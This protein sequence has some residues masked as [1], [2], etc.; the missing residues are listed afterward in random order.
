MKILTRRI[1]LDNIPASGR[2]GALV[3]FSSLPIILAGAIEAR[4]Y[5]PNSAEYGIGIFTGILFLLAS[6]FTYRLPR[7]AGI[8]SFIASYLTIRNVFTWN[9][10]LYGAMYAEEN[11]FLCGVLF[12]FLAFTVT[13]VKKY[14][15]KSILKKSGLRRAE[16]N[17]K[18]A[19]V[20]LMPISFI[21]ILGSMTQPEISPGIRFGYLYLLCVICAT[22]AYKIILSNTRKKGILFG[23]GTLFG[24][25]VTLYF[26]TDPLFCLMG[27]GLVIPI[28]LLLAPRR[29]PAGRNVWID[30]MLQQ[31]AR[32]LIVTFFALCTTGTLLLSIPLAT[33]GPHS[34]LDSLF[35]AVSASCV[36]GLS[37][38]DT[39]KDFTLLGQIIILALIQLGGLGIISITTVT[40]QVLGKRLSLQQECILTNITDTDHSDLL[41]SI[42][43]I[44]KVTFL[45]EAV[46]AVLLFFAFMRHGDTWIQAIWR[47]IFTSISAFCNAG[48]SLQS[49]SLM[50][51]QKDPFL[52]TVVSILIIIGGFAPTTTVLI[53]RWIKGRAIANTVRLPL[54]TTIWLLIFGTVGILIFEFN[55]TLEPLNLLDKIANAWFQ[56]VTL[57]TA[58]FNSIDISAVSQ[59]TFMLMV[60]LMLIGGSPGGTAGGVKT[61]TIGL[62]AVTFWS[63]VTNKNEVILRNRLIHHTT[64]YRAI[65]I[66]FAGMMIWLMVLLMLQVTH[67]L[68]GRDLLFEA[69]SAIATVGLTTGATSALN[70][71]GKI[72][73]VVTMFL[74]RIGPVSLFMLLSLDGTDS[75][76]ERA[77]R[78]KISLT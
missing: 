67:D 27:C 49:A 26:S 14:Q 76:A 32:V 17:A 4:S 61:S 39:E 75:H 41:K 2:Q 71:F 53:P 66:L 65:T 20:L 33:K 22:F 29:Q 57:R 25:I 52:L 28:I 59:P 21:A 62:L 63:N 69:S 68:P 58:G 13:N 6:A 8:I 50:P 77:P 38:L 72:I 31:P 10:D 51:Y 54:I 48:F 23:V 24:T 34:L 44:I 35:T 11:A 37:V 3:A 15:G 60:I 16:A 47:G 30:F 1:N 12:I 42:R 18:S 7:I 40:L 45:T 70:E 55:A 74:G 56:S 46:G 43:T 78:D 36:T 19:L 5:L 64:I 9:L 73:I